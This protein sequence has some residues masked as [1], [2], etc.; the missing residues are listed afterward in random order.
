MP[1]THGSLRLWRNC[2]SSH[3]LGTPGGLRR[4]LFMRPMSTFDPDRPARVHD[5]TTNQIIEWRTS[6]AGKWRLNAWVA[7]DGL[8]YYNGLILDGW[9]PL[10]SVKGPHDGQAARFP[11]V[12]E[13]KTRSI[14]ILRR[15]REKR[16]LAARLRRLAN[17]LSNEASIALLV[18]HADH[19]EAE[20]ESFERRSSLLE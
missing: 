17:D 7:S 1:K 18:K 9:E 8:A 3:R 14:D 4:C 20:A 12:V 16:E 5:A 2:A 11:A 15:A 19:L 6:W 10:S 13:C